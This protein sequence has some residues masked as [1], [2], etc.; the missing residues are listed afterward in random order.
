[1]CWQTV[2]QQSIPALAIASAVSGYTKKTEQLTD[3]YM[4]FL[5][6]STFFLLMSTSFLGCTHSSYNEDIEYKVL[7][8]IF[9]NLTDSLIYYQVFPPPPPIQPLPQ[10][11]SVNNGW[12]IKS[13]TTANR[14]YHELISK[15]DT[16]KWVLSIHDTMEEPNNFRLRISEFINDT[17]LSAYRSVFNIYAQAQIRKDIV[18]LAKIK[19]T[20]K[21]E[22]ISSSKII[23][24]KNTDQSPEYNFVYFGELTISNIYFDKQNTCG[25]LTCEVRCGYDCH[26]SYLILLRKIDKKWNI[27]KG[28]RLSIA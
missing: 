3:R 21:Y 9:G 25:F 12:D 27:Q 5:M 18:D 22:L 13:Y 17:T 26:Y 16:T 19:N 1:L 10:K 20:G 24:N 15:I 14:K 28:V 4:K 11:N 8:E 7:N 2:E 6:F 23:K